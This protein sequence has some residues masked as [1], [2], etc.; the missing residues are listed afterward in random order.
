MR[1][2]TVRRG[3]VIAIG[4]HDRRI[5]DVRTVHNG[6][7]LRLHTGELLVIDLRGE[8]VVTRDHRTGVPR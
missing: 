1:A 2:T 3:D 7:Q 6:R 4:G 5:I 8:Y